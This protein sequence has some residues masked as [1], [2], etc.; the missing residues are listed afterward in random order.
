MSDLTAEME[1][2]KLEKSKLEERNQ[3]L[4]K[5]LSLSKADAPA[6]TKNMLELVRPCVHVSDS[7]PTPRV[8]S[9]FE[10]IANKLVTALCKHVQTTFTAL[11]IFYH[12]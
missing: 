10:C 1:Q 8:I 3:L 5:V 12:Y 9:T 7:N 4:E 11:F 6:P 2:V